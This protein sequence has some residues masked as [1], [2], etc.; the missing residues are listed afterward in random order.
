MIIV[1]SS[2]FNY[3][4]AVTVIVELTLSSN[5]KAIFATLLCIIALLGTARA[6]N[7]DNQTENVQD[8]IAE[9]PFSTLEKAMYEEESQLNLWIAFHHPRGALP[10]YLVVTYAANVTSDHEYYNKTET[11]LWTSNSVYFIIPPHVFGFLSLFMGILDEDHTGEVSLTLSEE[12]SCWLDGSLY[13]T[14][15][16]NSKMN[17]LEILTE[18]VMYVQQWI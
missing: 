13:C 10:H 6:G 18:K 16:E 2:V 4:A 15:R 9:C 8:C 12:C 7:C 14:D 17:Y 3:T 1:S 11:Y 5:M